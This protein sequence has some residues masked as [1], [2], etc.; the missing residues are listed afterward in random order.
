MGQALADA[1]YDASADSSSVPADDTSTTATADG[2]SPSNDSVSV[3]SSDAA[4]TAALPTEAPLTPEPPPGPLPYER[5]KAILDKAYAERDSLK[6]QMEE[7][8]WAQQ[9]PAAVRPQIHRIIEMAARTQGD[10]VAFAM[11][12]VQEA[13][14][15]PRHAAA[16]KS[17]AARI[18]GTRAP[19]QPADEEPG[20]DIVVDGHSWYSAAQ[21]AKREQWL[22]RQLAGQMSAVVQEQVGP[23]ATLAQR[24]ADAE[25][26]QVAAREAE[27]F[28]T[29]HFE[30]VSKLPGFKEHQAEIS[31]AFD[32][33]IA[34]VPKADQDRMAPIVLRD[35]CN[36]ILLPKLTA[37]S[38]QTL[39]KTLTA[40]AVNG[41]L[42]TTPTVAA[43]ATRPR[44]MREALQQ[45][46]L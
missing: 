2:S 33:E 7:L 27:A 6:A 45:Q 25:A 8:S 37:T 29:T 16:L 24:V 28:A 31:A 36:D 1:G 20:P 5:H 38:S 19:S 9:V 22:T 40:K 18:L 42:G 23:L 4:Q 34:K 26:K 35:V 43:T 39:L 15:D 3:S 32:A 13:Q 11:E 44:S 41:S 12:L 30:K 21:Q 10:P 46:G 17:H 14:N